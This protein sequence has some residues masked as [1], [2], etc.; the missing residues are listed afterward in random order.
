MSWGCGQQWVNVE[1]GQ[2]IPANAV[3]AG[4]TKTDGKVYVGRYRDQCGKVNINREAPGQETFNHFFS[5]RT[6][7]FKK[8]AELLLHSGSPLVWQSV[9]MG[10]IVPEGAIMVVP[11]GTTFAAEDDKGEAGQGMF[12]SARRSFQVGFADLEEVVAMARGKKEELEYV[13]RFNGEP[14]VMQAASNGTVYGFCGHYWKKQ[15]TGEILV[16]TRAA[17]EKEVCGLGQLLGRAVAPNAAQTKELQVLPRARGRMWLKVLQFNIWQ[18]GWEVANGIDKIASVI[19]KS[20]ADIV[21]LSEVR[22]WTNYVMHVPFNDFHS[23]LKQKLPSGWHGC[24]VDKPGDAIDAGLVSKFPIQIAE[25]VTDAPRSFIAA[26]HIITPCGPL[27]VCSA[28]LDWKAYA[29]NNIRGYHHNYFTKLTN[30]E[31]N[32]DNAL[33][34]DRCSGRGAA[35]ADFV[36][37]A[38]DKRDLPVILG[39]D[40][41][42]CSHLDWTEPM[43]NKFGHAGVAVKWEHSKLLAS[44]GHGFID[45]WRELYPDPVTHMGATWPSKSDKDFCTSWAKEADERD[46]IDFIYYRG[47]GLKAKTG[48]LVG[49]PEYFVFG[50]LNT[51]DEQHQE[52]QSP[53]LPGTR[54]V[55]WPSDHKAVIVKFELVADGASIVAPGAKGSCSEMADCS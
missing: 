6:V 42:E 49:P 11:P 53:F 47:R 3:L 18:E 30:P 9:R 40:F 43:K 17:L 23:R 29:L 22:N 31:P 54:D 24:F 44:T 45:S 32:P 4:I 26:Y 14:G 33:E 36:R 12:S 48:H 16:D 55:P 37:W 25:S 21:T 15:T 28:H 41:N 20:E 50:K 38:H 27:W 35:L 10:D 7:V 19:V 34:I 51:E 13:G 1:M 52:D 46:R 8:R 5:N 39:G 2:L